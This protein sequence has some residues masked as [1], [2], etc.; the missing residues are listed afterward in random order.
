VSTEP[1]AGHFAFGLGKGADGALVWPA[2]NTTGSFE[3][4]PIYGSKK[5]HEPWPQGQA[6]WE[7]SPQNSSLIFICEYTLGGLIDI[8][9]AAL[10][11]HGWDG[12]HI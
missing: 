1:G 6:Q 3:Q 10:W 8:L 4:Y 11:L 2:S 7:F 9:A 12:S 5:I